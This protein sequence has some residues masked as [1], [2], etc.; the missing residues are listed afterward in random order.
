MRAAGQEGEQAGAGG[1]VGRLRWCTGHR[2]DRVDELSCWVEAN[3]AYIDDLDDV[4]IKQ[5]IA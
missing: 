1:N 5:K 3:R 4:A 2:S